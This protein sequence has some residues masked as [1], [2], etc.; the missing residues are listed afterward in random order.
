MLGAEIFYYPLG[1][2]LTLGEPDPNVVPMISLAPCLNAE[3]LSYD[4]GPTSLLLI[5]I[6][7]C[8]L[9]KL[10]YYCDL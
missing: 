1:A 10:T 2:A 3:T 8:D 5:W 4:P 6:G 9:P 7:F